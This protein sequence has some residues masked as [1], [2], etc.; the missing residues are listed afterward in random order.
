GGQGISPGEPD[1][2]DE[3]IAGPIPGRDDRIGD[4]WEPASGL[5]AVEQLDVRQA[6][7]VLTGDEVTL[8][9]GGALVAGAE[10]VALR[11]EAD[12]VPRQPGAFG[13]IGVQLDAL[14]DERD[15][16]RIVELQSERAGCRGSRQ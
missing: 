14:A 3:P 10:E 9:G 12:V 4:V 2:V 8:P 7:T 16:L 6:E 15:L 13:E 1:L 5:I 11:S